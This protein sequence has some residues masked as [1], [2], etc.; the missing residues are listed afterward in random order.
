MRPLDWIEPAD[1]LGLP[2][3]SSS[4]GNEKVVTSID[5]GSRCSIAGIHAELRR[6]YQ[7]ATRGESTAAPP[8]VYEVCLTTAVKRAD[9]SRHHRSAPG[10]APY[11]SAILK[12]PAATIVSASRSRG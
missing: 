9:P 8:V 4:P 2:S 6:N 1:D 10:Q 3:Q 12:W 7:Q 11:P 5:E